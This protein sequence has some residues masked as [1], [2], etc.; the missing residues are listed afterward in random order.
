MK[1]SLKGSGEVI[2]STFDELPQHHVKGRGDGARQGA[3]AGRARQGRGGTAGQHHQTGQSL[4]PGSAGIGQDPVRRIRSRSALHKPKKFF[5]A[6]RNLEEGGSIT[7]LATALVETG[8]RMDDLDLRSRS[9][10]AQETWSCTSISKLSEKRIFPAIDLNKSGTRRED[11]L[12][13]QD[14]LEAIWRMRRALGNRD[15]Q[16]DHRDDPGQP[17]TYDETTRPFIEVIRKDQS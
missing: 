14:E 8:S 3:A 13:D 12:M 2:Y 15:N 5:G 6:A 1:R 16:E 7:I 10:K 17:G 4:Q 11:L 9:S